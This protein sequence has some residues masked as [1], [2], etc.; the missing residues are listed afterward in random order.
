M[1]LVQIPEIQSRI[2]RI[3]GRRVM[4]DRDLATLYCVRA[5]ALRQQVKRNLRRFPADFMFV[6]SR[7][8]VD[9]LVSQN[10][11]PSRKHLGGYFPHAFTQ[12]GIAMLSSVLR[13]SRAIDV[14][15]AIMRAFV[16]LRHALA[17]Q[18]DL[19]VKV[20]R[21]EGK[22]NLVETDVRFMRVDIQK[23]RTP[24]EKT[25]PQVKGFSKE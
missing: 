8:E 22:V 3:R 13:S 4:L 24:A 11:I 18:K 1:K 19:V 23:L 16:K 25:G 14:N 21:L 7:L 9:L 5:I 15:I 20:E 10:V 12:E 2:Y 17:V 6:L